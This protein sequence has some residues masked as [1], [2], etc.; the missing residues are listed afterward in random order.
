MDHLQ[1]C[2]DRMLVRGSPLAASLHFAEPAERG[3]ILALRTVISEIAAVPDTVSDV[4][5][6]RSKLAWWR[7]AL[8]D[9][10]PHPAV[11]ALKETGGL[12]RLS[13]ERFEELIGNVIGTMDAPRFERLDSAW[14][15]CRGLGGPAAALEAEMLEPRDAETPLWKEVGGFSYLVRLVR[16]LPIDARNERW[17]VPLDLQAE[18][19]VSRR[20]VAEGEVSRA[21][22]GML[23]SWLADGLRRVA[24]AETGIGE[25]SRARQRHLLVGHALDR[26]LAARLMRR[27]RRIL[28]S[29][30]RLGHVG[31]VWCAWRAARAVMRGAA[32]SRS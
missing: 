11:M 9:E 13:N 6:G 12:D 22:D 24:D 8:R 31:N 3:R 4:E 21:F 28:V 18:Y 32:V 17:F 2:H 1:W 15:H 20:D 14:A 16:D 23:R 25:A 27:P 10:L 30:P 5:V 19:Q 7:D 29:P 26:R